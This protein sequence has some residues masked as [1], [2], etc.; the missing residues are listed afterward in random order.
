VQSATAL[1]LAIEVIGA[2][3][4]QQANEGQGRHQPGHEHTPATYYGTVVSTSAPAFVVSSGVAFDATTF[5][6]CYAQP[7]E[8]LTDEVSKN[9]PRAPATRLVSGVVS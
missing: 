8:T 6:V 5:R 2:A 7:I 9:L 3:L 1:A 4:A